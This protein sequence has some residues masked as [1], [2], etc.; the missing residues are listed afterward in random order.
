MSTGVEKETQGLTGSLPLIG[1]M[2]Q[3]CDVTATQFLILEGKSSF[4]A[5]LTVCL[6]SSH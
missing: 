2:L 6:K 1:K 4:T 5:S 3:S